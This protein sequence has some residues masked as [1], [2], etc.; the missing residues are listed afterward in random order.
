MLQGLSFHLFKQ[1]NIKSIIFLIG[2]LSVFESSATLKS[3]DELL[4]KNQT[5][6]YSEALIRIKQ[7]QQLIQTSKFLSE[8][9]KLIQVNNFFNQQISFAND[10]NLWGVKDYWATPYEVLSKGAGDCEDYSIAKYYSLI[11]LGVPEHKLRITYVKALK[12][13]QAH[14]VLSYFSHP[15]AI[16]TILDNLIPDIISIKQRQDLLPFFSFNDSGVW[17]ASTSHEKK[18]KHTPQLFMWEKL[19]HRI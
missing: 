18:L 3:S 1:S 11:K 5:K 8:K 6:H 7:W 10:I 4:Q 15:H 16:P 12:Y 17:L 9:E 2:L 13:N 19:K 14:M